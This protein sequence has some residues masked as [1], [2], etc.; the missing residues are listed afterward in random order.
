VALMHAGTSRRARLAPAAAVLL[1]LALLLVTARPTGIDVF[2]NR[3]IPPPSKYDRGGGP[4]T[5]RAEPDAV[6]AIRVDVETDASTIDVEPPPPPPPPDG[7]DAEPPRDERPGA[8]GDVSPP[9]EEGIDEL[10]ERAGAARP[11]SSAAAGDAV[12]PRPVE[13][14]WPETRRLKHCIGRSVEVRVL[15]GDDGRVVRAEA[16]PARVGTDCLDAAL[17][18]ARRIKFEP[19]RVGGLPTALWTQVRI[20]FE[21]KQ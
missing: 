12:P 20:D 19:G 3:I 16:A 6:I 18:A 15:V 14:T 1:A 7:G 11:R 5:S 13:I 9:S 10:L 2:F 17:D 8:R 21:R 4:P